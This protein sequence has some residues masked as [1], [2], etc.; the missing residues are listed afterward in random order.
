MSSNYIKSDYTDTLISETQSLAEKICVKRAKLKGITL[1]WKFWT[2]PKWAKTFVAQAKNA[3]TLLKE[4]EYEI[5]VEALKDREC[6]NLES[7]GA[8]AWIIP[9]CKEIK[10]KKK[11]VEIKAPTLVDVDV[12]EKPRPSIG[13]KTTFSKLKDL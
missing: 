12:N 11:P 8:K 7:L 1:G 2:D 6:R 3:A 9:I 10:E 13:K 4:F 5:I